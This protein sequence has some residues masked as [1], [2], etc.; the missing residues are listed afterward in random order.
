MNICTAA[1]SC[2]ST[3]ICTCT[4]ASACACACLRT[5][6]YG[7]LYVYANDFECGYALAFEHG[8]ADSCVYGNV[9]VYVDVYVHVC[10]HAHVTCLHSPASSI[11]F[12][13]LPQ[14]QTP[15]A[16]ERSRGACQ[17]CTWASSELAET[18]P[19]PAP[20]GSNSGDS[21]TLRPD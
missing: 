14:T 9:Y 16:P 6:A 11:V 2:T 13:S 17:W 21:R 7:S 10:V 20:I 19:D 5:C 4:Y 15:C 12:R 18:S 1:L 3:C 8:H